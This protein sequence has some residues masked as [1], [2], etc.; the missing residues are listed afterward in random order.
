M[1]KFTYSDSVA[2]MQSCTFN[3]LSEVISHIEDFG[4]NGDS[5]GVVFQDGVPILMYISF[6]DGLTWNAIINK[7]P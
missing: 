6:M 2:G 7:A 5:D 3:R 1:K 4:H